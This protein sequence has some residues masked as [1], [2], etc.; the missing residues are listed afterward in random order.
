VVRANTFVSEQVNVD[1]RNIHVRVI[2]G[3]TNTTILPLL[4]QLP[5]ISLSEEDIFNLTNRIRNGGDEV[6]TAKEGAGSATLSMV[7]DQ[8]WM[9]LAK[10]D[11]SL[12]L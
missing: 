6:V 1:V 4:S 10:A 9:I 8:G 3:H 2:G 5:S 7:S 12:Y 11:L